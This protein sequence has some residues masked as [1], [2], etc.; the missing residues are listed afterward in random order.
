MATADVLII[1]AGPAGSAAARSLAL[2]G[3]KVVLADRASFPRD[4]VCGDALIP[5]ALAALDRLSLRA[6]VL[7]AA[8]PLG[9][10]RIHAPGGRSVDVRGECACLPRE[11]L[12]DKLR[13]AAVEA[14][15]EFRPACEAVAPLEEDGAIRGARFR[16]TTTK[17]DCD[18]RARMTLLAT[19]AA[20]RPLKSFGVVTRPTPSATAARLYYRVDP[21]LARDVRHLCVS[22]DR[23]VC[24]GYGWIFPGPDN[25]FNVGVGYFYDAPPPPIANLRVL[26]ERFLEIFP[27]AREIA[28][29]GSPITA[30]KGAPLRTAL[31]GARLHRPGLLVVG[32]AAGAT[33]SFSGE[34]IGKAMETGLLAAD[35]VA[36]GLAAGRDAAAIGAAYDTQVRQ[37][38]GDR[39]RAYRVVQTWLV[40]PRLADFIAWRAGAGR[41]VRTR[42]EG[43]FN[44]TADPLELFSAAGMLKALF[45]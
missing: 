35:A 24:P 18:V 44:E 27:P 38:L 23:A 39:F 40:H 28:R 43:V 37:R 1:G 16:D 42:L 3:L 21:A 19:G 32:E 11:V 45:T 14:G 36:D 41:Y 13:R 26:L 8:L 12:D 34:G 2:R 6:R 5:D 30:L 9:S 10:I 17:G 25:V 31:A 7:D 22:Y 33:Y 15:A 4:K 20:G 29:H